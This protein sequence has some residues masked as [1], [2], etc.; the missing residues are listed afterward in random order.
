FPLR[1]RTSSSAAARRGGIKNMSTTNFERAA[2]RD[3]LLARRRRSRPAPGL[4][5]L[6]WAVLC[7]ATPVA[8]AFVSPK[9]RVA[10]LSALGKSNPMG[11]PGV[12]SHRFRLAA[13][14]A[15][16]SS[17]SSRATGTGRRLHMRMGSAAPMDAQAVGEGRGRRRKAFRARVGALFRGT[18]AGDTRLERAAYLASC[19][20]RA[21]KRVASK[22]A[23][24]VA[25]AF[26]L[27]FPSLSAP[28]F[29]PGG[30]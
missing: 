12:T 3:E 6:V 13:T 29:S 23:L 17:S 19:W 27:A 11:K 20:L 1:L 10:R 4:A 5:M 26:T 14:T 25:L 30:T 16:H 8:V 9:A 28:R 21:A 7:C 18:A 22:R 15:K 2:S 24:T